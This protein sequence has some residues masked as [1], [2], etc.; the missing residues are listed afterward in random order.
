M[1]YSDYIAAKI[2]VLKEEDK[3]LFPLLFNFFWEKGRNP[4]CVKNH[5]EF[6]VQAKFSAIR[7]I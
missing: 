7:A 3:E 6:V 1:V 5:T 4:D 2:L